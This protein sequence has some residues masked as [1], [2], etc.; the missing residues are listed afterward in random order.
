MRR[1]VVLGA[2]S[3]LMATAG[4]LVSA[5]TLTVGAGCD[6][7]T[8]QAAMNAASSGDTIHV[9]AGTYNEHIGL[10]DGVKLVGAGA[11]VTILCG[12]T[13]RS[14][15]TGIGVGAGTEIDGFT[16]TNGFATNGG[17]MWLIVSSPVVRNCVFTGNTASMGGG[18]YNH[19]SS[20]T[21]VGCVFSSNTAT[22]SGGGIANSMF[23]APTITG[24]TFLDNEVG[25]SGGGIWSYRSTATVIECRF[26]NNQ[27]GNSGSAI[28]AGNGEILA[29]HN[30]WGH[31]T[32][33]SHSSNPHGIGQGGESIRGDVAFI[34]WYATPTTLSTSERVSVEDAGTIF[35][36]SDT[37]QGGVGAAKNGWS[38]KVSGG[39]YDEAVTVDRRVNLLGP[40]ATVN[41]VS[42]GAGRGT[43]AKIIQPLVVSGAAGSAISG[44]LFEGVDGD[45]IHVG[46]CADGMAD[47]LVFCNNIFRNNTGAAIDVQ[48]PTV[49]GWV[50][51]SNLIDGN[52]GTDESGMWLSNLHHSFICSN[53]I[54]HTQYAGI[55]LQYS[56]YV[57]I[58]ANYIH[59]IPRKGIQVA[60]SSTGPVLVGL[61]T[62]SNTVISDDADEGGVTI[63]PDVTE[64]LAWLNVLSGN[65]CGFTVRDKDGAASDGV[66][67]NWNAIVG[68]EAFGVANFAWAGGD[69]DATLNWWGSSDGPTHASNTGGDGDAVTDD[70]IFSPWLG[71][72]PDD[73]PATVGVQLISPMLF[74]VDNVGPEPQA[75]TIDLASALGQP[76]AGML[77]LPAGY[78]NR[79][80]SAANLLDGSDTISVRPGSYDVDEEISDGV[81]I[82]STEGACETTL[83]GQIDIGTAGVLLGEIRNGFRI[84][85]NVRV[86]SGQDASLSALHWNDIYG[87]VENAGSGTLDATYNFWGAGGP[88]AQTIGSVDVYPD[89]PL[90][91]CTI[92][93]YIDDYGMTV[94]EALA[95]GGLMAD[96]YSEGFAKTVMEIVARCGISNEQALALIF[97]YNH[98]RVKSALRR[99]RTCA[100]FYELLEGYAMPAGAGGA[101]PES[102]VVGESL[103]VALVIVDPL[104]GDAVTDALVTVTVCREDVEPVEIAYFGVLPYDAETGMYGDAIDTTGWEPGTYRIYMGTDR[105]S[106][107]E[108]VVEVIAP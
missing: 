73:D 69:L 62:I 31:A 35:A 101:A 6:Y 56:G 87:M 40:N 105:M 84:D 50:I 82:L 12:T 32:G 85:G 90:S 2:L 74:V 91:S 52:T 34:P 7:S 106:W 99:T 61:N 59:D 11:D 47:G 51:D 97:E 9:A 30:W 25:N 54:R 58:I 33:P 1:C 20:P 96:G 66:H 26:S 94:A 93:G 95:F 77:S 67:V 98:G 5:D 8:I 46:P 75:V 103:T 13:H 3:L 107:S 37:I 55:I 72:D 49:S 64:M 41:P 92:I 83:T 63:Y 14:V 89:L 68:N 17:G 10:R 39:T 80:I 44:F 21:I 22:N 43:E 71:I 38:V 108:D 100:E 102:V 76:A 36:Y 27:A 24:C 16:I 29:V 78:L 18:I 42:A 23:S 65:H 60:H 86:L 4:L 104:T 70:V 28:Y 48:A 45:A 81:A 79:A 19:S 88:V 57:T 53:E 15:V